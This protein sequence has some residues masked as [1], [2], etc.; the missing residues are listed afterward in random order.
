MFEKNNLTC[1]LNILYVKEKDIITH[2]SAREKQIILLITSN[3]E[4]E[5]QW[6]YLAAKKLSALLHRI[7]LVM[8][9]FI[10]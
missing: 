2:N 7:T 6:H 10:V 5:E 3:E 1:T 8:V 4:K 9:V